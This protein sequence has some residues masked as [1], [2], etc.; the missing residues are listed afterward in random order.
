MFV[1]IIVYY[2]TEECNV[3][4]EL[5]MRHYNTLL[6]HKLEKIEMAGTSCEISSAMDENHDE[7]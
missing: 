3:K 5:R 6:L 7:Y 4:I 1:C 2:D